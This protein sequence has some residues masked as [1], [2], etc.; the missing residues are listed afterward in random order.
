MRADITPG[1]LNYFPLFHLDN[2]TQ[3]LQAPAACGRYRQA[4][5]GMPVRPASVHPGVAARRI[6]L[7]DRPQRL[8]V[9][10]VWSRM[11]LLMSGRAHAPAQLT[12]AAGAGTGRTG[13]VTDERIIPSTDSSVRKVAEQMPRKNATRSSGIKLH[14]SWPSSCVSLCRNSATR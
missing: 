8:S 13:S 9:A 7:P 11:S 10:S 6:Y 1:S 3:R 2:L 12:V 14:V 5:R 4:V